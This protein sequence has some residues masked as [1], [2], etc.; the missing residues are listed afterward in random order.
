MCAAFGIA[1]GSDS[2]RR[3]VRRSRR[4]DR[5]GHHR[6]RRAPLLLGDARVRDPGAQPGEGARGRTAPAAESR[7]RSGVSISS[8]RP[9]ESGARLADLIGSLVFLVLGAAAILWDLLIGFVPGTRPVVPRSRP[10][11][12]VDRRALRRSWRSRRC[13]PSWS[14]APAAGRSASRSPTPC[15]PRRRRPRALAARAGP[16][17]QPGVLPDARARR[18]RGG[19]PDHGRPHRLRHRDHRALG[20]HRR[21]PQGAPSTAD[22]TTRTDARS[23]QPTVARPHHA[24]PAIAVG[25]QLQRHSLP[26]VQASARVRAGRTAPRPRGRRG[27]R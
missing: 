6:R 21:L 10:L 4:H 12:V 27:A 5:R 23:R 25:G 22:G 8:R 18:R 9:R 15:S 14:T 17:P 1:L 13:S 26:I 3:H 19:R 11:A 24:Q 2:R 16:A 7:G 20:H